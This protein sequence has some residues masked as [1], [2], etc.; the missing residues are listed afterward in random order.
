MV[1]LQNPSNACV[2]LEFS[3]CIMLCDPW[4][5]SGIYEGALCNFPPVEAPEKVLKDI[6]HLFISHIHEDHW[7][8]NVIRTLNRDIEILIPDI[9]PNHLMEFLLISL[10]VQ[11][12]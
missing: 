12:L 8:L 2:R 4:F 3:D 10:I 11:L 5:T 1:K 9:Y 7:D 6:T